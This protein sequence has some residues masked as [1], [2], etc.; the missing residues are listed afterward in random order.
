MLHVHFDRAFVSTIFGSWVSLRMSRSRGVN[1]SV[2]RRAITFGSPWA[3][4]FALARRQQAVHARHIQIEQDQIGIEG[5]GKLNAL[6]AVAGFANHGDIGRHADQLFHAS[7]QHR[8]VVDQQDGCR[9]LIS[10]GFLLEQL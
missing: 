2:R 10:H 7:T 8:M 4:F 9:F 1:D 3:L 5:F 6:F